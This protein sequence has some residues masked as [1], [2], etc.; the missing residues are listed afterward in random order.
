MSKNK[1]IFYL[2]GGIEHTKDFG[3][4]WRDKCVSNF[5]QMGIQSINV[6]E[7][8]QSFMKE[9]EVPFPIDKEDSRYYKTLIQQ[10]FIYP[11]LQLITDFAD[12]LVIYYDESVRK[13]AGTVA[14]LQHAFS[15]G[16]PIYVVNGFDSI[17]DIP[18][19]MIGCSTK[20]FNSFDDLYNHIKQIPPQAF[21]PGNSKRVCVSCGVVFNANKVQC[22]CKYCA[23]ASNL[24][25]T[26]RYKFMSEKIKE[27]Q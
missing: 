4:G 12:A 10:H 7:L 1:P 3:Q 20:I 22:V 26:D 18:S 5:N 16:I 6:S 25:T 19:W 17:K 8:E 23:E 2:S 14:E 21:K 9:Y 24:M 15:M 13:G 11:D 27:E